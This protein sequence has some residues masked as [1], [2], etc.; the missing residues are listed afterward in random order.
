MGG[1]G[2]CEVK[3]GSKARAAGD[4]DDDDVMMMMMM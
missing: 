2:V 4:Y 3:R 1:G